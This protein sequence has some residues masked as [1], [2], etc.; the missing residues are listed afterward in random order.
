MGCLPAGVDQNTPLRLAEAAQIAF[1]I[2]SMTVSGLRRKIA[3]GRLTCE[4]IAGKQF[5]T[6]RYIDEMR[7]LCRDP[8]KECGF[9]SNPPSDQL[10]LWPDRATSPCLV[11]S[12]AVDQGLRGLLRL[13]RL[14]KNGERTPPHHAAAHVIYAG[15]LILIL[16][17]I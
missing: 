15:R 11:A 10:T 5:T 8:A 14:C 4:V 9:G 7:K 2:G 13:H 1:P 16:P 12:E 6:L 17:S 3:K